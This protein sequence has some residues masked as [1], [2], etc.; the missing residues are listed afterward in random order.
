ML[1][2]C[3]DLHA[4]QKLWREL[5][6]FPASKSDDAMSW[7]LAGITRIIGGTNITWIEAGRE[8][9]APA[10]DPLGGWRPS[11]QKSLHQ[12]SE[13]RKRRAV[14]MHYMNAGVFDPLTVGVTAGA[15]ATRAHLRK[16]L[17]DDRTWSKSWIYNEVLRPS[18]VAE[19]L[20]GAQAVSPSRE[21]YICIDRGMGD[22]PFGA[23][24]RNLLQLILSGC[25]AL[26]R[27]VIRSTGRD[28]KAGRLSARERQVLSLLLT[29]LSE[30]QIAGQ[31]GIGWRTT[32]E[33]TVSILRKFGVRG[34]D[35]SD[36]VVAP[37]PGFR[38]NQAEA[39]R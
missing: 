18:H 6:A 2:S 26:H 23:R 13:D 36:G 34:T 39:P 12:A 35:R 17:V 5:S 25:P 8:F 37:A 22:P 24:E 15:G 19:M 3:H 31:L 10:N 38:R 21:S 1:I 9:G 4:V 33:Y 32:H 30:K 7:C 11:T 16:E 27:E 20:V 14:V 28:G 29:D